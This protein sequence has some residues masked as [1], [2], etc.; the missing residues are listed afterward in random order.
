MLDRTREAEY[1]VKFRV[2]ETKHTDRGRNIHLMPGHRTIY[3]Q[4]KGTEFDVVQQ[5]HANAVNL[6]ALEYRAERKELKKAGK[7]ASEAIVKRPLFQY[8]LEVGV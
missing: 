5:G 3:H 7:P 4:S 6:L 2:F 8:T 1:K